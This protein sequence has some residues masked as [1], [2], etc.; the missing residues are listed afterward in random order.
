MTLLD[1]LGWKDYL[2]EGS[3]PCPNCTDI[4]EFTF[5]HLVTSKKNGHLKGDVHFET[6][7]FTVMYNKYFCDNI[8]FFGITVK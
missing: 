5:L 3:K 8:F 6:F 4:S 2:G 1:P 7:R